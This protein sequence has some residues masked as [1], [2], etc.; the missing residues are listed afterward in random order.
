[1]TV[2]DLGI[3]VRAE[4]AEQAAAK[5]D[6]LTAASAKAEAA[7]EKLGRAGKASGAN[8]AKVEAA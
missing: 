4:S 3:S 5:L 7:S 6:K 1:M 2:A 8:L